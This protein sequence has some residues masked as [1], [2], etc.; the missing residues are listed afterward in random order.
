MGHNDTQD[1]AG[2]GATAR[3]AQGGLPV[4]PHV[5]RTHQEDRCSSQASGHGNAQPWRVLQAWELPGR[6]STTTQMCLPM[7]KAATFAQA[8]PSCPLEEL[9]WGRGR[10]LSLP[11]CQG[12][13]NAASFTHCPLLSRALASSRKGLETTRAKVSRL[14]LLAGQRSDPAGSPERPGS[15]RKCLGSF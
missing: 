6:P 9:C 14:L 10:G 1:T 8:G 12:A 11:L 3:L 7:S 2:Y 15:L 4:S 13:W 5:L